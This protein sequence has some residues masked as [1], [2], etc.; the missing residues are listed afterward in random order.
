VAYMMLV[1]TS[2]QLLHFA[3]IGATRSPLWLQLHADISGRTFLINE[4]TDGPLL[5]CAILASVGC[6]VHKSVDSAVQNMVR[7]KDRIEPNAK[8]QETYDRLYKEVYLQ[9]RPSVTNIFHTL[10]DVRGGD[11]SNGKH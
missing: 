3:L 10:A 2:S 1:F 8:R 11:L 4:N 6:G 9:M 7:I 5:G